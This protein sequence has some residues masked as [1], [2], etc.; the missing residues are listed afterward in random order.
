[1]NKLSSAL[2]AIAVIAIAVVFIL[3]FRPASNATPTATGPLCAVEVGG[4]CISAAWF[5]ASSRLA[6]PP[7]ADPAR[8]RAISFGKKVADGLLEAWLLNQD[9]KRLG[10][11]VGDEEVTAEIGAGRA[12][13]SLPVAE[14]RQLAQS[15]QLVDESVRQI[16]VKSPKTKKF[17]AK[18]AE[19]NIRSYSQMSPA[20]FRDYQ[21]SEIL[22]ARMRDLIKSRV[23][24]AEGEAYEQ[25]SLEKSTVTLDYVRFDERFFADLVVDTTQKTAD[26]WAESNKAE[27]DKFWD[28]HKAQVLPECRSVREIWVKLDE[29]ATDEDK[30]KARAKIDRARARIEHGEDFA[31]VAARMSDGGTASLGGEIGCV[32]KGT[33]PKPYEDAV[34][35]LAAG[36]VSDV[37]TTEKGYFLIKLDQIAKDADAEKLGRSQSARILFLNHEVR[38]LAEEGATK[39]AAA[40]KGGKSMKEALDLYL[41]EL[42]KA[43]ADVR[44]KADDKKKTDDKKKADDKKAGDKN[45]D[46]RPPLTFENH[47]YRPTIETTLPFNVAG[48]PIPGVAQS[49]DL[50]RVAFQLEKAGEAPATPFPFDHGYVAVQLKERTPASQETWDKNREFYVA[51]MRA[52]KQNDALVV[53]VKR[54]QAKLG[55]D[56]KFTQ[57]F[58]DE[59][60][61]KPGD[62]APPPMDDD[63]G[64]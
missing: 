21:R 18:F 26:A 54:L 8:L 45:E 13:V 30:A 64:E 59:K 34:S 11:A 48:D 10:I 23:R 15:W 60:A 53:Y 46:D 33:K 32:P 47:P 6:P 31:D 49:A 22:A 50:V 5:K 7:G 14:Q 40:V 39:V 57:K 3:Q 41:A 58:V 43:T 12:H 28:S 38:R 16:P 51:A 55:S 24:I 56:A 62:N 52:A 9:A 4:S 1:V 29:A 19:K 27:L 42:A 37:V 20:E 17:D 36:K 63:P 61:Q 2:G 35:A 25:F 44:P